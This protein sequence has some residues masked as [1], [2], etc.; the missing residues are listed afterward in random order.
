MEPMTAEQA[1]EAAKGMTFEDFWASLVE[2]RA[3]QAKTEAMQAKTE[4][5]QAKTEAMVQETQKQMQESKQRM[6]EYREE[7]R[8]GFADL[9]KELGGL[10]NSLGR[11]TEA[12]F[13]TELWKLFNEFGYP[14]SKQGRRLKFMEDRRI[15]AEADFWLENGDY[16]MPVEVKTSLSIDDVNEHLDRIAKIRRYMDKRDDR[17]KIVGRS[18]ALTFPSMSWLTRRK[19]GFTFSCSA[20]TTL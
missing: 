19:K 3:M 15:I 13:S 1:R 17:R 18:R 14:F 16:V 8:K 2:A 4:A 9:R 7:N 12:L 11:I 20:A 5:M 6:D 10:G